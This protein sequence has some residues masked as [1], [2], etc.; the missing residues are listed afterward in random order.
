L[1][2]ISNAEVYKY[3]NNR[4][5]YQAMKKLVLFA[6]LVAVVA[7]SSCTGKAKEEAP[8]VVPVEEVA[9]AVEEN[10]VEDAAADS[11]TVAPAETPV[12]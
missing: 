8:E 12:Q 9:P 2:R 10:V 3:Y 1:Q 4:F 6:A 7:F 11:V 5:N